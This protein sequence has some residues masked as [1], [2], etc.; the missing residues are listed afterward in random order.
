M[1]VWYQILGFVGLALGSILSG[2]AISGLEKRHSTLQSYRAVFM[3]YSIVAV[4]KIVLSLSLSNLTEA[5]QHGYEIAAPIEGDDEIEE[6]SDL[7]GDDSE[8]RPLLDRSTST[9]RVDVKSFDKDEEEVDTPSRLPMLR[10][11]F[12]CLLFSIDSFASS[13]IPGASTYTFELLVYECAQ[14]YKL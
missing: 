4:I 14:R 8:C 12:T 5:K 2:V 13:L 1:L 10:L 7:E 11:A 6:P 3:F 9:P